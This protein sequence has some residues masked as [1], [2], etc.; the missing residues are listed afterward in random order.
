MLLSIF[1]AQAPLY[2]AA[3]AL[4]AALARRPHALRMCF[5]GLDATVLAL[6]VV[7]WMPHLSRAARHHE[8]SGTA[9]RPR[10]LLLLA[11]AYLLLASFSWLTLAAGA[12]LSALTCLCTCASF[13]VAGRVCAGRLKRPAAIL[14]AHVFQCCAGVAC[15]FVWASPCGRYLDLPASAVRSL[16]ERCSRL[17]ARPTFILSTDLPRTSA[18]GAP[19]DGVPSCAAAS[20]HAAAL[21][22]RAGRLVRAV[23]RPGSQRARVAVAA[24]D[25]RVE[26]QTQLSTTQRLRELL[27]PLLLQR[28]GSSETLQEPSALHAEQG[29]QLQGGAAA[30]RR[31]AH[32]AAA[33]ARIALGLRNLDPGVTGVP[34]EEVLV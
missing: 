14:Q 9:T 13:A 10:L 25:R 26:G 12:P 24:R 15:G 34:A 8:W 11:A 30:A 27:A 19:G 7:R 21:W 18:G 2:A 28:D 6:L 3:A 20:H 31:A 17:H 32:A 16:E 29:L 22:A 1:V 5:N 23:T 4:A 33:E